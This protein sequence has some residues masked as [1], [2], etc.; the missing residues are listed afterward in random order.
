MVYL[1]VVLYVK[2]KKSFLS[3]EAPKTWSQTQLNEWQSFY[4][5]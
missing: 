2:E 3:G 5:L 4:W 1:K